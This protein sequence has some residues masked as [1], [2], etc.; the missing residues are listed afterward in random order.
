MAARLLEAGE[1][2]VAGG[3]WRSGD[4]GWQQHGG[5]RRAGG[6]GSKGDLQGKITMFTLANDPQVTSECS[7][8]CRG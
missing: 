3:R 8:P 7:H 2:E 4:A 5:Q 6:R 1:E